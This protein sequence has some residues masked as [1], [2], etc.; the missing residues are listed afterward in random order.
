MVLPSAED[1]EVV[2]EFIL[3]FL[4]LA[5]SLAGSEVDYP[6]GVERANDL[7]GLTETDDGFP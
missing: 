5:F 7:W 6:L 4:V 3:G 1:G 2:G